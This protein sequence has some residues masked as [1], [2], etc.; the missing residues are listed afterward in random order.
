MYAL[1]AIE[2]GDA[3]GTGRDGLAGAHLDA[4]FGGAALAEIG[5]DEV[6][7]IGKSGRR[8]HLSAD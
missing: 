5:I 2:D 7:M 4:H 8:L 3:A 6:H 1:F